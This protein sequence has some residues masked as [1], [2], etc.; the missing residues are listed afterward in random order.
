MLED[1]GQVPPRIHV[2]SHDTDEEVEDEELSL[3]FSQIESQ[4]P[5][6]QSPFEEAR[7]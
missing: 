4:L 3:R 1:C 7:A 6:P 2:A 5:V